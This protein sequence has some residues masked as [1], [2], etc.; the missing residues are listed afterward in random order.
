[1]YKVAHPAVGGN[2]LDLD[3]DPDDNDTFDG[4]DRF[5][6]V[7]DHLWQDTQGTALIKDQFNYG[8]DAPGN[9][10]WRDVGPDMSSPPSGK[11]EFYTHDGLRRLKTFARGDLTSSVRPRVAWAC[12]PPSARPAAPAWSPLNDSS[13]NDR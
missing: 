2:D 8:Y 12:S 3:Y 9:R 5:G 4:W 6:R 1:M 10:K 11:D 7:V 13:R